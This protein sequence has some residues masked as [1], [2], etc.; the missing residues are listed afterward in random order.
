MITVI[1]LFCIAGFLDA[2]MDVLKTRWSV[3]IFSNIKNKKI[4][5]WIDPTSWENKWK[6]NDEN[7]G[8]KFLGSST[9][10]VFLMDLWHFC[11]FLMLFLLCFGIVFYKQYLNPY[12]DIFI[13]YSVFTLTFQLFYELIL[14]KKK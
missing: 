5:N 12:L 13:L 3:S 2:V 7:Q 6:N 10:F 9:I 14:I 1:I 8:E 4:L 11:K